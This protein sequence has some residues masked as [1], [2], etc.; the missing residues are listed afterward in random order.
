MPSADFHR[1]YGLSQQM[2]QEKRRKTTQYFTEVWSS[3]R[4]GTLSLAIIILI[5]LVIAIVYSVEFVVQ[6]KSEYNRLKQIYD[7]ID[8]LPNLRPEQIEK[9]KKNH[10]FYQYLTNNVINGYS[11]KCIGLLVGVVFSSCLSIYL[12]YY[13]YDQLN[14]LSNVTK[15]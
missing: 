10:P 1:M 15:F 3:L 11:S 9:V 4:L 12:M 6:Y 14:T 13:I 2:K 7:K 8:Y 5:V